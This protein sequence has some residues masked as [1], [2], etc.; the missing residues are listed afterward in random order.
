MSDI[1]ALL[2]HAGA[3]DFV[4]YDFPQAGA[5]AS[6]ERVNSAA[7]VEAPPASVPAAEPADAD[8]RSEDGEAAAKTPAPAPDPTPAPPR[9]PELRASA[10]AKPAASPDVDLAAARR[11]PLVLRPVEEESSDKESLQDLFARL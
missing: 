10:S 7:A 6:S 5:A 8:I 4:Y 1:Q 3:A 11:K 9:L 2:A